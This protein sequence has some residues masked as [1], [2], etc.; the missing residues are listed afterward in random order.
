[1]RAVLILIAM[2]SVAHADEP[3]GAAQFGFTLLQHFSDMRP[4]TALPT[5][6][7]PEPAIK[8][9]GLVGIRFG[10]MAGDPRVGAYLALDAA[11]GGQVGRHGGFAYDVA[12]LPAGLG[13]HLGD[14]AFVAVSSG[15]AAM[16][17]TGSLDDAILIPLQLQLEY[18]VTYHLT[19]RVRDSFVF[20]ADSRADGAPSLPLGDELDG[21]LGVRI[22]RSNDSPEG[23]FLGVAYKEMLG[24]RYVGLALGCAI[25]T[26]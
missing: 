9:L 25:G 21:M 1:M 3:V 11:V 15:L 26:R 17:A 7:T 4:V 13:V 24:T 2:T 8:Q 19:L 20:G 22:A 5:A 12:V 6:A 16:G 23:Y 14:D 10:V 18:G